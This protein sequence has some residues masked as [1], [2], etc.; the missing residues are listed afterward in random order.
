MADVYAFPISPEYT[1]ILWEECELEPAMPMEGQ[2]SGE[3][4][5][6]IS[7]EPFSFL[8]SISFFFPT[9]WASQVA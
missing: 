6:L 2:V 4:E 3:M 1:Q 7:T 9:S 8:S 5:S